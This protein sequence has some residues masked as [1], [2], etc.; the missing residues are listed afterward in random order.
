[1]LNTGKT[2][3]SSVCAETFKPLLSLRKMIFVLMLLLSVNYCATGQSFNYSFTK[4]S[5]GYVNLNDSTK[6]ILDEN[7][8]DDNSYRIPIG[9]SFAFADS[10]FDSVTVRTNGTFTF[11]SEGRYNFTSLYKDFIAYTD[12]SNVL[13]STI[14]YAQ[15]G[16]G[17][18]HI[19]KIEFRNAMIIN[20]GSESHVN[21]QVWLYQQDG[22]IELHMGN[23]DGPPQNCIVGLINMYNTTDYP[24]G[25]L[26]EGSPSLPTGVSINPGENITDLEGLP[27]SGSV[28]RFTSN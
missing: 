12:A 14:A 26:L 11:D 6:T 13:Q 22:S 17:S 24:V 1:M 4:D 5:T 21:F 8:W 20:S 7:K 16:T 9:F 28:Y 2:F 25:F 19:L 27:A 18:S 10:T 15:T 23:S 3:Y